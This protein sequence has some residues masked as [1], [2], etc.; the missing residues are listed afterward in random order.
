MDPVE[1]RS[2]KGEMGKGGAKDCQ[3]SPKEYKDNITSNVRKYRRGTGWCSGGDL[4]R[5]VYWVKQGVRRVQ[6][7]ES[8]CIGTVVEERERRVRGEI[9]G[10]KWL[11]IVATKI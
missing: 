1:R 8:R 3:R 9:R 6:C 4:C 2:Y 5:G 7:G 10:A 11:R